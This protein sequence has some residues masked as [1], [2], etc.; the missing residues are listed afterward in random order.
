ML[1]LCGA[2]VMVVAIALHV[3]WIAKRAQAKGR[4]ALGWVA[5]GLVLAVAGASTGYTLLEKA[6]DA[7][8]D[9]LMAL[10]ATAP[11][12]LGLVGLIAIVLVLDA[13]PVRVAL[14]KT[15]PVFERIHGAGT[16]SIEDDAIELRWQ[17][18]TQRLARAGLTATA[19]QESVRLVW[20]DGELLVMPTGAPATRDGRIKQAQTIAARLSS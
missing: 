19:D 20:N 14:G 4:S 16:L 7:D 1:L 6:A 17:G 8:N 12:T 13:L 5:L 3:A 10:F 18:H 15:W 2:G 11:L 9:A